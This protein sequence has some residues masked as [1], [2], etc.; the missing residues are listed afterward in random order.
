MNGQ[1]IDHLATEIH[2]QFQRR[3]GSD[4][5]ATPFTIAGLLRT[6]ERVRPHRMIEV[7]AGI[8][9][10]TFAA[11]SALEKLHGAGK[12]A[13]TLYVIESNEFCRGELAKN[14]AQF[15]GNYTL[16]RSGAEL[17]SDHAAFDLISID[18]RQLDQIPR[19]STRAAIYVEGD[20]RDRRDMLS[21]QLAHRDYCVANYRPLDRG[22]GYWLFQLDPTLRERVEMGARR[23]FEAAGHAAVKTARRHV[24][25]HNVERIYAIALAAAQR[26]ARHA[27][28]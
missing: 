24:G 5:I 10:L 27:K 20:M 17:P 7:G 18:G 15:A 3:P 22:K 26:L 8:G 4:Y 21:T 2:R 25:E 14:L 11:C 19:L 16:L 13:F 28:Y 23:A 12:G 6:M 9:T 1:A